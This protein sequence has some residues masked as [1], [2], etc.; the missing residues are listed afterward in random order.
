MPEVNVEAPNEHLAVISSA[1]W[2]EAI[3][4]VMFGCAAW[5]DS[6]RLK[7]PDNIIALPQ[8]P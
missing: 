1:V 8:P 4:V 7:V 3:V 6:P 5:H 2:S